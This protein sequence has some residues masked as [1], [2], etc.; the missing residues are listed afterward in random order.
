MADN[1]IEVPGNINNDK[2]IVKVEIT[3]TAH[4]AQMLW[5][6]TSDNMI[7]FYI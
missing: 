1:D 4:N 6:Q 5:V 2:S 7:K 3:P